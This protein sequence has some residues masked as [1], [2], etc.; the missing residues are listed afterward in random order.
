[1]SVEKFSKIETFK[2]IKKKNEGV[3]QFF[4]Q[5]KFNKKRP[6]YDYHSGLVAGML[7]DKLSIAKPIIES[8]DKINEDM[9]KHS[10]FISK[11]L[12]S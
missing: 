9:L 5:L 6:K 11:K 10:L 4:L 2:G 7:V 1:M 3:Q 12:L 8:G